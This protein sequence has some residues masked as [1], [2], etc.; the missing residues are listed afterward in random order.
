[1]PLRNGILNRNLASKTA[2]TFL[3]GSLFAAILGTAISLS[4]G[5]VVIEAPTIYNAVFHYNNNVV[6]HL[7]VHDR[8]LPRAVADLMVGAALAV[9]GA[10][11]QAVTKNPLASPGIMGLNTGASFAAVLTFVFLPNAPRFGFIAASIGG[12]ALGAFLVYGLASLSRG[13]LTPVRLALTGLAVS[14]VLGSIGQAVTVYFQL[15]QDTLYWFARGTEDVQWNDIGVFLPLEAVGLLG[16]IALA[17]SMS[18]MSLGNSVARGLG[19]HTLFTKFLCG[20]LVL[21][22][23]GGAVSLAGA[24]GFVGLMTPHLMRFV[25]GVDYRLVLPTSAIFG[26]LL[27]LIADIVARLVSAP[28]NAPVPVSVITSL[29]GVPFFIYLICRRPAASHSGRHL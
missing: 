26:A 11:M 27:V 24:I 19:Q 7:L 5:D 8:R 28:F 2:I 29:I 3:G 9:A 18:V 10:I 25:V 4:V 13:G 16:A 22:L 6:D 14:C 17:S 1:M 21:I 23:A 20:L 15:G 12:A